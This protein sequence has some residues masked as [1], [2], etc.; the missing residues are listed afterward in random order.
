MD[1]KLD[2]FRTPGVQQLVHF[3]ETL[4]MTGADECSPLC[5]LD[6]AAGWQFRG[7]FHILRFPVI[8]FPWL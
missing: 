7:L 8:A 2:L 1:L 3:L 6:L 4:K 5:S